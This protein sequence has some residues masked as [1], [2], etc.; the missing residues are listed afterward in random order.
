MMAVVM[1][2]VP[3]AAETE[4]EAYKWE[5]H[6]S[7]GISIARI[8]VGRTSVTVSVS[9]PI[10]PVIIGVVGIIAGVIAAIVIAM[11]VVVAGVMPSM[12]VTP[13]AVSMPVT[14]VSVARTDGL[15]EIG[16]SAS[17]FG[18]GTLEHSQRHRRTALRHD[19]E[20]C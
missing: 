11:T 14:I 18:R 3:M 9:T 10:V 7:A 13:V 8:P 19:C 2:M 6:I 4:G 5:A 16:S 1:M 15:N 20:A 12:A 17:R